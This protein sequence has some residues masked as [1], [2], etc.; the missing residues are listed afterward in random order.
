MEAKYGKTL[1]TLQTE[2]AQRAAYEANIPVVRAQTD[3]LNRTYGAELVK[4]S[5][6]EIVKAL[7]DNPNWSYVE[8]A[9]S[10][11]VPKLLAD[12]AKVREK[13]IAEMNKRPA[14][15]TVSGGTTKAIT[16]PEVETGGG[17]EALIR[18]ALRAAKVPF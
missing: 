18:Q 15:A 4:A 11:L 5:E 8:A 14:A 13:I 10:V 2:R 9:A 16:A 7:D 6:N 17:T 3:F 12:E 1:Q